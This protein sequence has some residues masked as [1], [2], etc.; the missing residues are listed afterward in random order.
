[1]SPYD[2]FSKEDLE[3]S[4]RND[5]DFRKT[6]KELGINQID[7]H[8]KRISKKAKEQSRVLGNLK[9]QI[10]NEVEDILKEK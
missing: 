6:V 5:F 8:E 3:K 4:N 2:I 9:E 1:M 10:K 7:N